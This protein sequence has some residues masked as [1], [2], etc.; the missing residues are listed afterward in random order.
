MNNIYAAPEASLKD[1][2]QS[3][4]AGGNIE[5]AIQGNIDISM[6]GIMGQAWGQLKGFKFTCHI[7][8]LLYMAV[9][10][11]A[12]FVSGFINIG[13]AIIITDPIV[14]LIASAILQIAITFATMPIFIGIHL[15]GMRHAE[16]RSISATAIFGYFNKISK[17]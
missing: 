10:F 11:I 8:I 4:H 16:N 6:L 1:N 17:L 9:G 3:I 5:D 12:S 15:L 2:D 7:A 14:L 13:L